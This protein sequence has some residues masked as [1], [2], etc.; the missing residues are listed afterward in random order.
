MKREREHVL[1]LYNLPRD[2]TC[3]PLAAAWKESDAGILDQVNA[4]AGALASLGVP[5]RMAGIK[6]LVDLPA[7][8]AASPERIV[9]NL[10]ESIHDRP[11]DA[12]FVPAICRAY[13][14]SCT[15]NDTHSLMF[16]LDKWLTNAMLRA[17]GLSCPAGVRVPPGGR[18]R[19]ADLPAPPY[20]V[21]PVSSDASE[22]I[23]ARS[24]VAKFGPALRAAVRRI[25][26]TVG[27]P[28][29]VERYIE[30][31]E[32]NAALLER[33]GAVEVLAIAEID[34]SAFGPDRPRIVDYA[35]KWLPDSFEF[36][37]TPRRIPAELTARQAEA[38]RRCALGAWHALRC[39]DYTRVDLRL[40]PKGEPVIIE[41]NP[42]PDITPEAGFWTALA[43]AGIPYEQF[44]RILL[45]N[46]LARLAAAEETPV[47]FA[48][49]SKRKIDA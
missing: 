25:H 2:A 7:V 37:N 32:L 15:G 16:A 44:V 31:R 41:V 29:L 14:K 3:R 40:T 6:R 24:V 30:G 17:A 48:I 49:R 9:F 19:A 23:D 21:K 27:Q 45:D 10:V 1:L 26:D 39:R 35:A 12:N 34:F 20:I 11:S 13:G 47:P 33:E 46:A 38:V 18:L 22:G 43:A 28:A 36:Q 8:L 4:V 42:N 5:H